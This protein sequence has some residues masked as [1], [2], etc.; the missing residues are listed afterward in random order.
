MLTNDEVLTRRIPIV[1]ACTKRDHLASRSATFISD[2]LKR[3]LYAAVL[4]DDY[5][6]ATHYAPPRPV[7]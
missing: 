6:V 5:D 1:F 2:F 4:D 7:Q 3:N